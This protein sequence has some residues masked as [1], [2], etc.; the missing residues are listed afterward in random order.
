MDKR[1]VLHTC[2]EG[3]P[4]HQH[5]LGSLNLRCT[6]DGCNALENRTSDDSL[7]YFGEFSRIYTFSIKIDRRTVCGRQFCSAFR[8][9]FAHDRWFV[10]TSH[11]Q[12]HICK[13]RTILR[14][15]HYLNRC[16]R[17]LAIP[18]RDNTHSHHSITSNWTLERMRNKI[19]KKAARD[20]SSAKSKRCVWNDCHWLVF[21][22]YEIN[23]FMNSALFV[24]Y[25][26]RL[27]WDRWRNR[28]W[29]KRCCLSTRSLSLIHYFNWTLIPNMFS[30]RFEFE[31]HDDSSHQNTTKISEMKRTSR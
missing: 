13:N 26:F 31:R 1:W 28:V 23:L 9:T 4:C 3:R 22:L 20:R 29:R 10:S 8:W 19:V 17:W 12:R 14:G 25:Y 15:R 11:A 21:F 6:S 27:I 16:F 24:N 2:N 7:S 30:R 5:K 18:S